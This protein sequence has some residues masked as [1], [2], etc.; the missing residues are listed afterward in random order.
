MDSSH[1]FGGSGRAAVG[2]RFHA[3]GVELGEIAVIEYLHRDR[4][5]ATEHRETLGLN[6]RERLAGVEV[7]HHDEFAAGGR[8]RDHRRETTRGVKERHAQE[9]GV[10]NALTRFIE[11]A[12]AEAH[13]GAR[14][15]EEKIHQIRDGVSMRADRALGMAGRARG[16]EHRGVVVT[17]ELNVRWRRARAD[18][19]EVF[20][21]I[22]RANSCVRR[23]QWTM[24]CTVRK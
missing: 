20:V 14:P 3:R 7:V 5:H 23:A 15:H 8:G 4:R 6:Q 10:G 11:V 19:A 2:D 21:E 12:S 18:V 9:G 13:G 22:D 17:R 16:V 24:S 1:Q